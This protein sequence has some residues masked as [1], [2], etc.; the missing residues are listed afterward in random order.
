MNLETKLQDARQIQWRVILS[1]PASSSWHLAVDHALL[2]CMTDAL[3]NG[4]E[5][6][7]IFRVY[8]FDRHSMIVGRRQD[9]RKFIEQEKYELT[10]RM[11]GGG[12]MFFR[13]YDI[14]VTSI[15]PK[16]LTPDDLIQSY[17]FFNTPIVKALQDLGYPASL[18]RTSIK[19]DLNGNKAFMGNAQKRNNYA[20][21]QHG[22]LLVQDYDD[23]IFEMMH[24]SETER[25]VWKE[26]VATLSMFDK[27]IDEKS[28]KEVLIGSV[29]GGNPSFEGLS[30]SESA[31]ADDLRNRFYQNPEFIADGRSE[32]GICLLQGL[33]T[34][35]YG[36]HLREHSD[37][38]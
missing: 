14:H 31:I 29:A 7:P 30:R 21:M 37:D 35:N 11:S 34:K 1:N 20:I 10:T 17:H 16:A 2:D 28:I 32:R 38:G 6:K 22:T 9:A 26:Q 15:V 36:D 24:A 18:G 13:P 25:K 5:V 27:Q 23:S 12:H 33:T 8:Q 4:D 3:K 19:L